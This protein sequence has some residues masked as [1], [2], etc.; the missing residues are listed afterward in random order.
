[1][2]VVLFLIICGILY[3][4]AGSAA[5]LFVALAVLSEF[6][7]RG[8]ILFVV[9]Y[10]FLG[11]GVCWLLGVYVF[12][13]EARE[14]YLYSS[15]FIQIRQNIEKANWAR[16]FEESLF[17]VLPVI[18]LLVNSGRRMAKVRDTS[19]PAGRSTREKSSLAEK[20]LYNLFR[21]R[22]KW[23]VQILLLA[24]VSV[25]SVFFTFDRQTKRSVQIDYFS[26]R[27]M[28][29]EVLAAAQEIS[30][31]RY[32]PFCS[33][34]VNRA[35]YY[36][37][38]M[39]DELFAYPQNYSAG[40]L[41]FSMI[42][43]G[44]VVFMDRAEMCLELGLVSVAKKIA[45]EFLGGADN[46]PFILR[47]LALINIVE[48]QTETARFFLKALNR[49]LVYG[50]EAKDISKRF[51]SD[52]QL[53][54]DKRIKHLRSVMMST[55]Y[56]YGAYDEAWLEELLRI[57]KHNKMAFEYL[58][59]HYLLTKQLD[60]F[61]ENLPRLDDFGYKSIPRHY[62]EAIVL[63]IGTTR[64]NVDLGGRKISYE[65]VKQYNELNRVG[66]EFD[67]DGEVAW[68]ALAP[69][70]GRTYYFYFIFGLSGVW[71]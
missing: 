56:L 16:I 13:L 66:A 51:E 50:K 47:Q 17:V 1:L 44:N 62:Q 25:P 15:P 69:R 58:M 14:V 67:Y 37:G 27:R 43:G 9:L 41:V 18:V 19:R 7:N 20:T 28:W 22:L 48:G 11:A 39:G 35:L 70:F 64:K 52:P 34:S 38:R 60:K 45:H 53:E 55:D 3:W 24:L 65:A 33:H 8:K 40:D 31:K 29:P 23:V 71:K 49:N 26:S 32:F 10:L 21:G 36:T 46:S 57:N 54:R 12:E 30:M 6:F 42:H 61:I 4:I 63:Y 2:R 5:L 68:K 59:S